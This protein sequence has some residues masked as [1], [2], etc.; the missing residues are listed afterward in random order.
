MSLRPRCAWGQGAR[1]GPGEIGDGLGMLEGGALAGSAV[2][3][4]C[5]DAGLEQFHGIP[6][7]MRN[8]TGLQ[9]GQQC[10]QFV[11]DE[12]LDADFRCGAMMVP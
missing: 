4:Q 1:I 9:T 12:F 8:H 6:S 5:D 10:R 3:V 11:F 7:R 2:N